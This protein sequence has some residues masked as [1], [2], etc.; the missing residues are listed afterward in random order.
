[1]KKK[2]SRINSS[3]F[4]PFVGE[5]TYEVWMKML[6]VLVPHGRTHRLAVVVAGMIQYASKSVYKKDPD[7]YDQIF[8]ESD[9]DDYEMSNEQLAP[10]VETLFKDA[11]AKS[12]RVNSRGAAYSIVATALEEYAR[13]DFMPWE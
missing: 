12:K 6:K 9:F 4:K 7:L 5:E 11:K 10:F 8:N 13:W 1:M 3:S 2:K